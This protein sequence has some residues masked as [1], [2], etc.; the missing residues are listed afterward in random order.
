MFSSAR[1]VN[2]VYGSAAPEP[3][4]TRQGI[5]TAHLAAKV[6]KV[7]SFQHKARLILN[8]LKLEVSEG[9]IWEG[10]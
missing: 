7:E 5:F 2:V 1:L 10:F 6:M 9:W 4:S 3:S 8:L